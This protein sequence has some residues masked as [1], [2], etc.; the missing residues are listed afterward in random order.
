M[1]LFRTSIRARL[2]LLVCALCGLLIF[3]AAVSALIL[4]VVDGITEEIDNKWL[5]ATQT[6]DELGDSLEEFRVAEGYR[7]LARSADMRLRAEALEG[8][9]VVAEDLLRRAGHVLDL[10]CFHCMGAHSNSVT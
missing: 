4:T 7:A 10:K 5:A 9:R 1:K 6:I 2:T 3:L 8:G